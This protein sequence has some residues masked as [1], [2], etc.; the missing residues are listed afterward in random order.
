MFLKLVSATTLYISLLI[1]FTSTSA[2][3]IDKTCDPWFASSRIKPG[4]NCLLDC[5]SLK[6]DT[7]T[8]GCRDSCPEY[9]ARSSATDFIFKLSDLYPGLTLAERALAAELPVAALK[10]YIDALKAEHL[11]SAKFGQSR[12]N[13]ES[14][15]CRH[16]IWAGLMSQDIGDELAS[17]ILNAHENYPGNPVDEKAMDLANN[18]T[19]LK[20][21]GTLQKAKEFTPEALEK[22]FDEDLSEGKLTV[23]APRLNRKKVK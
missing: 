16:F 19:G 8:F 3:S 11:C 23:I 20:E 7:A 12:T 2:W 4:A 18:A 17:K 15:A 10:G 22:R 6:V 14:D 9:C 1:V 5:A 21:A 13:D